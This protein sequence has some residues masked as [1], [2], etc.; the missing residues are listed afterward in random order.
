M[1]L[2]NIKEPNMDYERVLKRYTGAERAAIMMIALGKEASSLI[3]QKMQPEDVELLS[4]KVANY[5]DG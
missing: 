4:A 5:S 1:A 2:D 3:F